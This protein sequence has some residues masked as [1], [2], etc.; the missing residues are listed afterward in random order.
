MSDNA[1]TEI[2]PS[3]TWNVKLGLGALREHLDGIMSAGE[4]YQHKLVLEAIWL[5]EKIS[6]DAD[7][8]HQNAD[9]AATARM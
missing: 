2:D 4:D 1:K 7:A 6:V 3:L 9:E 8:A 5:A